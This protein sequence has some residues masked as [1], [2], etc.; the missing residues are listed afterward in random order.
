MDWIRDKEVKE[1]VFEVEVVVIFVL[2]LYKG[3]LENEWDKTH[4]RYHGKN[5]QGLKR[6]FLFFFFLYIF[7]IHFYMNAWVWIYAYLY[8]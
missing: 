7:A 2:Y 1:R 3:L 4:K 5:E 8:M 6:I